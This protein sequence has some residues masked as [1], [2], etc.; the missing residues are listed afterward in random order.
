MA[1]HGAAAAAAMGRLRTVLEDRL[2]SSGDIGEALA[3]A[4]RLAV[5]SDAARAATVCVAAVDPADG[6]LTYCT[7]AI[8]RRC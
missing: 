7:A 8:R 1:G 4:D 5:R 6:R 2:D 3:A